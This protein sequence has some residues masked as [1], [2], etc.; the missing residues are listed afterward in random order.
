M[1]AAHLDR[2]DPDASEARR[3]V[4]AAIRLRFDSKYSNETSLNACDG[5]AEPITT[6]R[7]I[8]EIEARRFR[9]A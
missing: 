3:D 4:P 2:G 9:T 5:A 8:A 1:P 7:A 6:S